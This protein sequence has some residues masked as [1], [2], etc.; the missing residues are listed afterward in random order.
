MADAVHKPSHYQTG[1]IETIEMI[2][3]KQGSLGFG[4]YCEGNVYKYL[5]RWRHKDG[6]QDLEKARVYL[7]WL[8][9]EAKLQAAPEPIELA[10]GVLAHVVEAPMPAAIEELIAR[11]QDDEEPGH[12]KAGE[13]YVAD[14]PEASQRGD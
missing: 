12:L 14:I 13:A 8:L 5:T 2:R 7:D 10:E 1:G 3:A 9:V 6:I 11:A 4:Y